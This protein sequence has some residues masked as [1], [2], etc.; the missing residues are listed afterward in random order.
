MAISIGATAPDCM[1][2]LPTYV[3]SHWYEAH[4]I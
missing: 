3:F 1:R 2:V 4:L